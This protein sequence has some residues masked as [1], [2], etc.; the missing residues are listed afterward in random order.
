[1]IS[2][3]SDNKRVLLI[4]QPKEI[5]S[6]NSNRYTFYTDGTYLKELVDNSE[7]V[8]S[9]REWKIVNKDILIYRHKD[10]DD[11]WTEWSEWRKCSPWV[12]RLNT[13]MFLETMLTE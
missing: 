10:I 4:V 11:E 8:S 12:D 13:E 6:T 5:S 3:E 2:D 1:M 9:I 7:I